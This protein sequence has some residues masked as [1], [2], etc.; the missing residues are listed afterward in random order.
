MSFVLVLV[1]THYNL[2]EVVPNTSW[3]AK[4]VKFDVTNVPLF[5]QTQTEPEAEGLN[6]PRKIITTFMIPDSP[7][8]SSRLCWAKKKAMGDNVSTRLLDL[9]I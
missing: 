6:E 8:L 2:S 9:F 1:S 3:Y 4:K 7:S 5:L